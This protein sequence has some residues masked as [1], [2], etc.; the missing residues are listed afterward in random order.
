MVDGNVDGISTVK[1]IDTFVA[2]VFVFDGINDLVGIDNGSTDVLPAVHF[3]I[4]T[5]FP[6]NWLTIILI[7]V[8]ISDPDNVFCNNEDVIPL[9]FDP[10][11]C[12]RI[13]EVD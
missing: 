2:N 7:N 3:G 10:F 1:D 13:L 8:N 12:N 9:D 4:N 11:N 6:I 5:V